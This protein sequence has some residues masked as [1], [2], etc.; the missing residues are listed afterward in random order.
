MKKR[1]C[2]I[3]LSLIL[4]LTCVLIPV[5]ASYGTGDIL[6]EVHFINVGQGDSIYIKYQSYDILIDAGD[7]TMDSTV[8]NYLTGKVT[9]DL[10][11]VIATHPDADHIGGMDTVI[12]TFKCD[13][14]IDSGYPSTT[15]TYTNYKNAVDAE[16][17]GGCIYSGDSDM[18]FTIA[19]GVTFQVIET[20]DNYSTN[21]DNSVLTKLTYNN[22]SYLFTGDFSSTIES[23]ILTKP[24]KA[25]ILK[26]GHHGSQY[27]S[28]SNFISTVA[29]KVAVISVGANN[30]YGHP[31]A[32]TI[33]TLTNAGADIY[34][35][36]NVGNVIVRTNGTKYDVNGK[37]YLTSGGGGTGGAIIQ[38]IDLVNETAVIKN[39]STSSINM[40]GWKL[41]ST[42]GPQTYNFPSNFTLAAGASV[43]VE[44]GPY[45]TGNGTTTLLWTTANIWANTGD[46]G[47][48]YNSSGTLVSSY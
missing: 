19:P 37:E 29:P 31:A 32:Q 43:T 23:K 35:T 11:L 17:A 27:S 33:T 2:S 8:V 14:I 48:L 7:N 1:I 3:I 5:S 16:V 15:A 47:E 42:V 40:T 41:V 36:M 22:V 45:A 24:I 20:G 46:P 34:Q 30:T 25:N 44:S 12:K 28:S 9:G 38:S 13:R 26:V 21:N 10:D 4:I 18:T 6:A 39:T